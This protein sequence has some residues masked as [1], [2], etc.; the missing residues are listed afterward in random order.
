MKKI[1]TAMSGGVDSAVCCALLKKQGFDVGG[2]TMLLQ[3]GAETEAKDA[4]LAAKQLGVPFYLFQ[5]KQEFHSM[6]ETYFCDTYANGKTPNPCIVCN[7]KLKFGL[8]LNEALRLGYD[9]IATGH[10][11]RIEF[12]TASQRWLVRMAADPTKDQ[13]YMLY[14]LSQDQLAHSILPLGTKTKSEVREIAYSLH[15]DLAHKHDSQDICFVPDGD[16]ISFLLRSG[17]QLTQGHYKDM[18]G[19]DLGAHLGA[20]CY[21]IGQR[22]GLH[23]SCGSRVYVVSKTGSD[24]IIGS[25]EDLFSKNVTV[26]NINYIAV[27]HLETPMRIRAKLRYTPNFAKATLIPNEIGATLIFDEPQRAV[28]P[29]QSAVFY[30]DDYVLGGGTIC[31]AAK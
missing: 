19:N 21:T 18:N 28:T 24:V 31:S 25:N 2:A 17:L 8:F 6:V 11:A 7:K 27:D 29:G 22:R 3:S 26:E 5:W 10:Y 14:S 13:T 1:L 15:L 16:Y 12:D 9:S 4:E 30:V 20:E 23:L